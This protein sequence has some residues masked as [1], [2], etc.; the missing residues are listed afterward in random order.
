MVATTG[1]GKSGKTYH[2]YEC[3]AHRKSGSCPG[4]RINARQ[5]DKTVLSFI[6]RNLFT[7]RNVQR[8][9]K[10]VKGLIEEH[11]TDLVKRQQKLHA[12]IS[13]LQ[14]RR[15]RL[16][17]VL[18]TSD[19]FDPEDLAPRIAELRAEEQKKGVQLNELH[20]LNAPAEIDP[21]RL[22]SLLADLIKTATPEELVTFLR[23][24]DLRINALPDR[25]D[26]T[27]NPSLVFIE[28]REMVAHTLIPSE[29]LRVASLPR[30]PL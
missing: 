5:F 16:L 15:S 6:Q 30:P 3:S 8:V 29:P 28:K 7:K 21:A 20:P 1:R 26:F 11:N 25:I 2:Y 12:E 24:Y 22:R 27:A 13:A 18:E 14:E 19:Q 10:T 4:Q 9:A 23:R 17:R